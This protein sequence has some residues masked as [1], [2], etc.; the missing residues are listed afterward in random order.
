M[1]KRN[2]TPGYLYFLADAL[3]LV[4]EF[5]VYYLA[6]AGPILILWLLR[7]H[8]P[9]LLLLTGILGWLAAALIFVF[10]IVIIK[11]F[12]VGNVPE[13]RFLLTSS[14]S[15]RWMAADR[16]TKMSVRSP[17]RGL[18]TENA[19]FRYL[20]YRGMG[21]RFDTTFMLGP[22]AVIA[23]PWSF[24]A[25]TNV[26]IGADAVISGLSSMLGRGNKTDVMIQNFTP[27]ATLNMMYL[28][29]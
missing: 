12:V 17:F 6:F 23:E 14:R 5:V 25:G 19:F 11:R 22:R 9:L 10:L 18:I 24:S 20:F 8:H 13:G 4:V 26:L 2:H 15:Y 1:N 27:D 16:L 7:D 21:A 28:T 3:N 29:I